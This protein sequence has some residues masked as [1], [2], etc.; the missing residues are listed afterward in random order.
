MVINMTIPP[1]QWTAP[2]P[3]W[4]D[5]ASLNGHA[6]PAGFHQP[7]ILRFATDDFMEKFM[8]VVTQEPARL[9][10]WQAQPETWR[11][12]TQEP[13]PVKSLPAFAQ[14]LHRLRLGL[15]AAADTPSPE[16]NLQDDVI[17]PNGR[18]KLYQPAHQRYYLISAC[19]VCRLPGLPD[20]LFDN[21]AGERATFVIR[22]LLPKPG[23]DPDDPTPGNLNQFNEYAFVIGSDGPRWQKLKSAQSGAHPEKET[24]AF[25]EEQ[26]PLFGTTYRETNGMARRLLAGVIPVARRETY[27]GT[28]VRD[29]ESDATGLELGDPRYAQFGEQVSAPWI[30]LRDQNALAVARLGSRAVLA[31]AVDESEEA[32]VLAEYDEQVVTI[33]EQKQTGSWYLLLD[34]ADYLKKYLLDVW[35]LIVSDATSSSL[36][37]GSSRRALWQKLTDL[38]GSGNPISL[39]AALGEIVDYRE[40][41]EESAATYREAQPA[42]WPALR[43]AMTSLTEDEIDDLAVLIKE[44]LAETQSPRAVPPLPLAA[45]QSRADLSQAQWF[46]IRCVFERPLCLDQ[47]PTVLSEPTRAF[48]M[49]SFF[50]PDAPARPIRISLPLDTSPA[51]LRKFNK[52]TAFVISDVL[53]CQIERA[54]NLTLGDLVL[55]VLPWPFHKSLPK[56]DGG[57]CSD[58]NGLNIGMICSLSIPIITICALILLMIIVVLLDTIFRWIPYFIMCFQLPSLSGKGSKT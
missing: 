38:T 2:A 27:S 46:V 32:Q 25:G 6:R 50:D 19:L 37:A 17:I 13:I 1:V 30:N 4:S 55:S 9:S 51:G 23:S 49:A 8:D 40:T 21:N 44:A 48:Q 57:S 41:L 54:G 28:I 45:T 12:P 7:H 18:L 36:P 35:Q 29:A 47:S 43:F 20:R 26:L 24:L 33:R 39:A 3:L 15:A 22:R 5:L 14:R 11:G 53:A 34:F 56:P 42:G 52:N 10:K 31:G 16:A 58:G